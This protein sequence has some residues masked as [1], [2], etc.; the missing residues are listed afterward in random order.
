VAIV[1]NSKNVVMQP[2]YFFKIY[3]DYLFFFLHSRG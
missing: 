2:I 1:F 3:F